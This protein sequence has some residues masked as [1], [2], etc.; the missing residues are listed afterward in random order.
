MSTFDQVE[1]A[2]YSEIVPF[3]P[4]NL[5]FTFQRFFN[6]TDGGVLDICTFCRIFQCELNEH[7]PS[8]W[9]ENNPRFTAF[10]FKINNKKIATFTVPGEALVELGWWLRNDTQKLGYDVTLFAGYTN[11]HMG[12]F[13]TP[14]E[15]DWGGYESQLTF[16]GIDTT[17]KIRKAVN[18]VLNKIQ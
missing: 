16:W 10:K 4:T 8:S 2:S 6:C 7:L 3:G 13:A 12:Y 1:I 11:S 14:R 5:N 18:N 15:Y 9:I 17:I